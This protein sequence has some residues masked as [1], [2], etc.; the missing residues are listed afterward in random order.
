M[1]RI[2]L[3]PTLWF[4]IVMKLDSQAGVLAQCSHFIFIFSVDFS[5]PITRGP[6]YGNVDYGT[7]GNLIQWALHRSFKRL[8][9]ES[10]V[11]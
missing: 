9:F 3:C 1:S 11:L 5:I 7:K 2:Y 6:V 4:P 10:T 8:T